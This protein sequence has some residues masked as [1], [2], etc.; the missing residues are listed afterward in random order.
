M[1]SA[2][3]P[4]GWEGHPHPDLSS[5]AD[6]YAERL[7]EDGAAIATVAVDLGAVRWWAGCAG[8]EGAAQLGRGPLA[9]ARRDGERRRRGRGQAGAITWKQADK[10]ARRAA[11]DGTPKGLR[12]AAL[13]AVASDACAR[14]SEV[15][16]LRAR[17]VSPSE[18]GSA[19]LDV[20]AAKT[21]T[22]RTAARRRDPSHDS[23]APRP[24]GSRSSRG[25]CS[26]TRPPGKSEATSGGALVGSE[27]TATVPPLREC[28]RPVRECPAACPPGGGPHGWTHP[29]PPPACSA[30]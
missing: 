17:D 3:S 20:W 26:Q 16:A 29:A 5:A 14:V 7:L 4:N 24:A 11:A 22:A 13:L 12:D 9:D 6:A 18:D 1:H 27:L 23:L 10:L 2:G 30:G 28:L 21:G 19:T 15:A 25:G 8:I